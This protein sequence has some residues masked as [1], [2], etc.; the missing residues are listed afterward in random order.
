MSFAVDRSSTAPRQIH[1]C[2]DLVL[3]RSS[4]ES[5]IH[6]DVFFIYSWGAISDSLFSFSRLLLKSL[7]PLLFWPRASL[8]LLV[9][10]INPFIFM[11]SCILD[12]GFGFLKNSGFLRFLWNFWV[13]L[14]CFGNVCSCIAFSLH[15]NNV[16]CI[17][18]VW[19][20]IVVW[21]LVGLYWVFTH[22]AFKV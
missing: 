12:L 21:V 4:I 3:D 8:N 15:Y 14:C 22:D 18:D 7:Y 19:L 13:G 5:S 16:S 11:H 17:L 9:S 1:F 20:I 10:V 6:W 2:R